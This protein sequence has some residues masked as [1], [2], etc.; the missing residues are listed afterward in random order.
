[1]GQEMPILFSNY[2]E[3]ISSGNSSVPNQQSTK[4]ERTPPP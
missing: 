1:M 3:L 2:L 4:K